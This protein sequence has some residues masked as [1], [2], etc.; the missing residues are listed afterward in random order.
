[1]LE[2]LCT[3]H[4]NSNCQIE[5][6]SVASDKTR[7]PQM[8]W[9]DFKRKH[10]DSIPYFDQLFPTFFP[11]INQQQQYIQSLD[12]QHLLPV[13]MERKEREREKILDC[14]IDAFCGRASSTDFVCMWVFLDQRDICW[15]TLTDLWLRLRKRAH[16]A[17]ATE[18][19]WTH[20]RLSRAFRLDSWCAFKG[21]IQNRCKS[22]LREPRTNGKCEPV[23]V[24]RFL[25]ALSAANKI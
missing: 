23:N 12:K 14:L 11:F 10:L 21:K 7:Q 3:E 19:H 9:I 1:M 8:K 22:T 16:K 24:R 4:S 18:R 2:W 5:L 25:S 15:I 13:K 17:N 20:V 6:A